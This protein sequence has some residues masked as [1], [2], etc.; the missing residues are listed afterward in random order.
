M[1]INIYIYI[2]IY[3]PYRKVKSFSTRFGNRA[4]IYLGTTREDPSPFPTTK[5]ESGTHP[6]HA[7]LRPIPP[8]Q[9]GTDLSG[10]AEQ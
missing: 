1:F 4:T 5:T 10:A 6:S 2:L 9:V 8:S 3:R 7:A